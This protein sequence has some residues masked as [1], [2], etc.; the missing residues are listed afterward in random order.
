MQGKNQI[1]IRKKPTPS[2]KYV[3]KVDGRIEWEGP[4][5]KRKFPALLNDCRG[6]NI[7]IAWKSDREF[8]IV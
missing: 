2:A 4:D 5:L 1:I 7:S 3:I 6:K 8:L